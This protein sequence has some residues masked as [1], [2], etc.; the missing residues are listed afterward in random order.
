ML[1]TSLVTLRRPTSY[2]LTPED[3]FE[4]SL[5]GVFANDLQNHHGDSPTST[6]IYT[7]SNPSYAPISLHTADVNSEDQRQKFA[8][9][10]WNAGIL[11]AE[12]VGGR[13]G[14]EGT[15]DE[16]RNEESEVWAE[17]SRWPA[18]TWWTD[19]E[20][21]EKWSVKGETVLELGA[22]V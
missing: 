3:I 14:E 11:M 1:L 15:G 21:E 4:S 18:G 16:A 20:E 17:E 19:A 10:L 6:L 22:G 13:P 7:P 9:Y 2:E 8:H 12:L 5:G